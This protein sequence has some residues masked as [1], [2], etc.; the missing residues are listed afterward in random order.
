[1]SEVSISKQMSQLEQLPQGLGV[2]T[3]EGFLDAAGQVINLIEAAFPTKGGA[4]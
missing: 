1:M 3:A 2:P 4:R